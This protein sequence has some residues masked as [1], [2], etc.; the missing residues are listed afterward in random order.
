VLIDLPKDVAQGTGTYV[1]PEEVSHRTYKPRTKGDPM[2]S[3]RRRSTLAGAKRPIIYAGGGV[4]NS[5]PA[6]PSCCASSSISPASRSRSRSWGSAPCR[7]RIRNFL[8][9]LGMHGTYE[10]NLT[11]HG[12]DVMFAVGSRF[13]DRVTGRLTAFSPDSTKIHVDIDPSSINKNV[14]STSASSAT[15]TEV[16]TD[17]LAVWK[18]NNL[19]TRSRGPRRLVEADRHLARS[20]LPRLPPGERRDHQAA[21]RGPSGSVRAD[22]APR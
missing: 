7:R 17:L 20:R 2:P 14:W 3:A 10:A 21:A 19:K 13:D 12:A 16:L 18:A 4:I 6:R 9:M 22:E 5:G 15:P 1:P 11:M 8:G